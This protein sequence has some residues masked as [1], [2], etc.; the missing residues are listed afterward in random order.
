MQVYSHSTFSEI[1][2]LCPEVGNELGV[3]IGKAENCRENAASLG[4]T[5]PNRKL[6]VLKLHFLSLVHCFYFA[7]LD[8]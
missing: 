6:S 1:F 2:T 7:A 8:H 3:S 5:A 4:T